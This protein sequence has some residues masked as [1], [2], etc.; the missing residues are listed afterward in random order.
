[1]YIRLHLTKLVFFSHFK[2]TWNFST[3][4]RKCRNIKRNENPLVRAEL[5]LR[6]RRQT[7]WI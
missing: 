2:E 1:M 7:W 5:F 6:M 3:Y 4:F